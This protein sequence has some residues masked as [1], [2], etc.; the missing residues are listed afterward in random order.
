MAQFV[1]M[2]Y[3]ETTLYRSIKR[4]LLS[5]IKRGIAFTI[6]TTAIRGLDGREFVSSHRI[7]LHES[8][9]LLCKHMNHC[10]HRIFCCRSYVEQIDILGQ[11]KMFSLRDYR[12]VK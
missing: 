5:K 11:D 1:Y 2:L 9:A 7:T 12:T 6:L 4:C 8:N 3:K 10:K